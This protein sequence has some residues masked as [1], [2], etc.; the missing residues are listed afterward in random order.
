MKMTFI[1]IKLE[2]AS[3]VHVDVF[4]LYSY[5]KYLTISEIYELYAEIINTILFS[6]KLLQF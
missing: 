4:H 2:E 6:C 3:R 5:L 1:I